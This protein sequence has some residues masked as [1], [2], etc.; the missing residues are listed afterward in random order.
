[1]ICVLDGEL[2]STNQQNS[3]K[4]CDLV[5]FMSSFEPTHYFY[6]LLF[7]CYI[8]GIDISLLYIYNPKFIF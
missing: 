8:N 6:I 4:S 2:T 5:N 3:F 7:Y 1:M